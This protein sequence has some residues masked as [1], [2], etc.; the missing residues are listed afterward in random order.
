MPSRLPLRSSLL[1]SLAALAAF[2]AGASAAYSFPTVGGA[3][4]AAAC[5]TPPTWQAFT[6]LSDSAYYALA[7]G[8]DFETAGLGWTLKNAKIVAG[9]ESVGIVP[10]TKSVLLGASRYGGAAEVTS[11][12]FCVTRDH[13]S[14]RFL[15]RSVGSTYRSGFGSNIVYRTIS[16]LG[17]SYLDTVD[18]AYG[19]KTWAA[20]PKTPLATAIPDAKFAEGVLVK[21]KFYLPS[22]NVREGG[23]LQIDNLLID[24]YRR[25]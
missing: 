6:K 14:F 19:S 10:G 16:N 13:P 5:A 2:P 8:G 15:L 21:I 12:E 1:A 23:Q 11:P 7:P 9:N 25:S 22:Y 18:I 3:L 4:A 17:T 20:S 24:P